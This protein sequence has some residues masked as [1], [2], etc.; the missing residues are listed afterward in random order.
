[1]LD[2]KEPKNQDKP[3]PSGRFVGHSRTCV[4]TFISAL[5][6]QKLVNKSSVK[7]IKQPL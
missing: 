5:Q 3:D 4:A 6:I 7:L 2:Q 1:L